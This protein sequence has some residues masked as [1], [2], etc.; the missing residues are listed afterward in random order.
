MTSPYLRVE[1][2]RPGSAMAYGDW[3]A[4]WYL[5]HR[6]AKPDVM[7][8]AELAC[9]NSQIPQ[10]VHMHSINSACLAH[11]HILMEVLD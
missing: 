8:G 9:L 5:A 2:F 1:D 6:G 11:A 7:R 10:M 3:P 4:H